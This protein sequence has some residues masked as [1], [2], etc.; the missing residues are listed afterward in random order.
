[1]IAARH[2]AFLG[3]VLALA[4]CGGEEVEP[5]PPAGPP[6]IV[7]GNGVVP[8]Y[9]C[10]GSPGCEKAEGPLLVGAAARAI[11]PALETWD[12]LDQSGVWDEGEPFDDKNGNGKWDGVWLAGF[13]SGR[14]ATAIHDDIWGRVLTFEQGDVSYA[15]VS[16]DLIGFFQ[17]D[18]V[19]VRLRAAERGLD[20]DH[21]LVASTHVHEAPDTMGMWGESLAETGYSRE[22]IDWIVD[23]VVDA[24]AEAKQGQRAAHLKIAEGEAPELV[25]D[26]RLPKV[27]DQAIHVAQFLDEAD[28]PFATLVVWGNHPEALGS[29]NTQ[30]TSDYPHYLRETLEAQ[31]PGTTAVFM[32]GPLG[33]L[34]TT[35]RI[36]GCPDASGVETCAQGTWERAEYVGVGA[37]EAAIAALEGPG[38]AVEREPSIGFRRR[39]LFVQPTNTGLSLLV[40]TG[41]LPRDVYS[42]DHKLIPEEVKPS[43]SIASVIEGD[44]LIGTEVNALQLGPMAIATVPGELY[45]ELWLVKEDGSSYIEKPENA[46][47]PEAVPE[48]PIQ[49]VLPAGV[50]P[51]IVNNANDALGYILPQ[52]QFDESS[53]HAYDPEGQYG[54]Q[55]SVGYA[56]G[57][58]ITKEFAAMYGK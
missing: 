37:A 11:T 35:I 48:I 5:L 23:Q 38:A 20:F 6:P 54:E 40:L 52:T 50:T 57:P 24:L 31:Y 33:G 13:S 15:M 7:D 2:L 28:A 19:R 39:S 30:L 21:I 34:M 44:V 14:A 43:L 47:F 55:N 41:V 45:P 12:D 26:T 25:N 22:Y 1:M 36:V 46:D 58:T 42:R 8:S 4:G 17:Q 27:I 29:D 53:P 49:A 32:N 3:S 18:A 51:V 9:A 16:L 10:P 56:M